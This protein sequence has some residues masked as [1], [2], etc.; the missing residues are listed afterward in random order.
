MKNLNRKAIYI[1]IYTIIS[2]LFPI[3]ILAQGNKL[4]NNTSFSIITFEGQYLNGMHTSFGYKLNPYI[5][6]GGGA[7]LER[8]TGQPMYDELTASLSMVPIF[9]EVRYTAL[10]KRISPVAAVKGGYKILTNIPSTEVDKWT[11]NIFPPYAWNTY[12][13]YDTFTAG[14][15]FF[16]TEVGVKAN[17]YKHYHLFLSADYSL[18]SVRGDH[19]YWKYEY[20][21]TNVKEIHNVSETIAYTHA[22]S[23]RIG[24]GF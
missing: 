2:I 22:F 13:V 7:G 16:T 14:G 9:A 11:F 15:F 10:N 12:Y 20:R 21:E 24:F 18:W 23:I 3:T 1:S 6:F 17:I 8:Y 19:H 5:G 4:Y